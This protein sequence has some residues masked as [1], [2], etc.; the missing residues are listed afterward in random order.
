M[1]LYFTRPSAKTTASNFTSIPPPLTI[2]GSELAELKEQVA[3]LRK[4]LSRV[5][6]MPCLRKT[7]SSPQD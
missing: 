4:E 6:G 2:M 3:A 7:H 5:S 1:C